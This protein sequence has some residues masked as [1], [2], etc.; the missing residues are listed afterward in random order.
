MKDLFVLLFGAGVMLTKNSRHR[1]FLMLVVLGQVSFV[2]IVIFG[3][4]RFIETGWSNGSP[5]L[6]FRWDL[7]P[8]IC[9]TGIFYG[10]MSLDLA[11]SD[12]RHS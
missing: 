8:W 6:L 10:M 4:T 11:I 5:F 12:S 9:S 2:P 1:A 3:L 7:I